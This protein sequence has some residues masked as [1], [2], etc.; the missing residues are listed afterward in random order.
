MH[1]T[2]RPEDESLGK[3]NWQTSV[4]IESSQYQELAGFWL[5]NTRKCALYLEHD[6]YPAVEN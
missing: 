3:I 1:F 5:F 6:A 2:S 4:R